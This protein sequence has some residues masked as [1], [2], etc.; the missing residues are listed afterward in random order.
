MTGIAKSA[1]GLRAGEALLE[2]CPYERPGC[3]LAGCRLAAL[4][5]AARPNREFI[6]EEQLAAETR[7]G[8]MLWAILEWACI[9]AIL[10]AF[11][12]GF[13]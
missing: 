3:D 11:L 9:G 1:V 12:W 8:G 10:I 7:R 6:M 5:H 13:A 4:C 2:Y